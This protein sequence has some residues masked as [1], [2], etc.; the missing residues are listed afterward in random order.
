MDSFSR[1]PAVRTF[2]C[3]SARL[4]RAGL[5]GLAEG[6]KVSYELATERGKTSAVNLKVEG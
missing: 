5:R 4:K 2:S 3:T 1:K 6:Q